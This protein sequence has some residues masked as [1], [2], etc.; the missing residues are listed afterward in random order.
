MLR[1]PTR[2]PA[3]TPDR[4]CSPVTRATFR[5]TPESPAGIAFP[6]PWDGALSPLA[7]RGAQPSGPGR[8]PSG[9]GRSALGAGCSAGPPG[10]PGWRPGQPGQHDSPLAAQQGQPG[11]PSSPAAGPAAAARTARLGSRRQGQP[12]Q[13]ARHRRRGRPGGHRPAGHGAPEMAI[14]PGERGDGGHDAG[15]AVTHELPGTGD[16]DEQ[17]G[18]PGR[19]RSRRSA[20]RCAGCAME[21]MP[22]PISKPKTPSNS[23]IS[24]S[25]LRTRPRA[26]GSARMDRSPPRVN[27]RP[28]TP[29][30]TAGYPISLCGTSP[31]RE[32][33]QGVR[34]R[35]ERRPRPDLP[36]DVRLLPG[37]RPGGHREGHEQQAGQRAA[38]PRRWRRTG[39]GMPQSP[40]GAAYWVGAPAAA[41]P[42]HV[43]GRAPPGQPAG[44]EGPSVG[45]SVRRTLYQI[46]SRQAPSRQPMPRSR[47]SRVNPAFSRARCSAT[48]PASVAASIRCTGVCANR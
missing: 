36:D 1:R 13:Q 2:G 44:S 38:P 31:K 42:G 35:Q 28:P 7:G 12:G 22:D 33:A 14:V 5:Q 20:R 48:L 40:R 45:R 39:R 43:T 19:C 16:A 46:P 27:S 6:A 47:P 24:A 18:R 11:Q 8:Q 41:L 30:T 29:T 23:T 3:L 26:T 25:W 10:T 9:A 15:V 37:G 34:E 4:N 17:R 32:T 21:S